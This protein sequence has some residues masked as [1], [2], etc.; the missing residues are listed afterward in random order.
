MTAML[1]MLYS[2]EQQKTEWETYRMS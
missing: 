1:A 2:N